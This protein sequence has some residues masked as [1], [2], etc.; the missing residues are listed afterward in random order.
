MAQPYPR[1]LFLGTGAMATVMAL[2]LLDRGGAARLWGGRAASVDALRRDRENRRYLAGVP[3][4]DG[5][6]FTAD[7]R[8]AFVGVDLVVSAVPTQAKREV[9]GRLAACLPAAV[10]VV[11]VAKG[12]ERGTGLRPTQV[13]ADVLGPRCPPLACLSG[14][15]V[16]EELAR[17]LPATLVAASDRPELAARVQATF[18]TDSLRVYTNPDPVGVELAGALKNVVA[19][20]AGMLDGQRAGI[21]AKSALLARGLAEMT[22]LGRALGAQT[23]TFFGVA[24]VGDLATTCFSPSGRNRRCGEA[25]GRGQPPD[26]A[27][28]EISGVV[29]GV[30]TTRAV[31]AVAVRLG[32]DM[33]I[34]AAVHDVLFGG[35]PVDR[36]IRDLM[37]REPK[38]ERF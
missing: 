33:P 10:P 34:T 3:L 15:S 22:R 35:L 8:G 7:D 21:N 31:R 13:V 18:T 24:G 5:L 17:R 12:F 26:R 28:A 29:E 1:V 14:P 11:S 23:P 9:W 37:N 32:V 27:A 36:A 2:L 30:E 19:L 38:A 6:E 25:I 16:A 20:A 4:P